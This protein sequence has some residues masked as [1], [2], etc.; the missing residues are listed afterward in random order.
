MKASSK[1]PRKKLS[2]KGKTC[3]RYPSPNLQQIIDLANAN[4]VSVET[5]LRRFVERST[6]KYVMVE[7]PSVH[8]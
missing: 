5:G 1:R 4:I 7:D 3:P 8:F 2:G 6:A